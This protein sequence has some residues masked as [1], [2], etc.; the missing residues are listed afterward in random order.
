MSSYLPAMPE[1]PPSTTVGFHG[2][3]KEY[4]PSGEYSGSDKIGFARNN[5]IREGTK[6]QDKRTSPQIGFRF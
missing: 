5:S 1:L 2:T 6:P 3:E 4:Q